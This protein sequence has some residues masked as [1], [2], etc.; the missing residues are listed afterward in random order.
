MSK[1]E[2]I[3]LMQTAWLTPDEEKLLIWSR[4]EAAGFDAYDLLDEMYGATV[5]G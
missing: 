4:I 2:A 5:A 3:A 1:E